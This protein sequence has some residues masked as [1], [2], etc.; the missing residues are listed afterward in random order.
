MKFDLKAGMSWV[1]QLFKNSF[2]LYVS[3]HKHTIG[4]IILR[5][6]LKSDA[7]KFYFGILIM[8]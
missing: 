2:S 1:I 7:L 6:T 5:L 4:L 8:W 3:V